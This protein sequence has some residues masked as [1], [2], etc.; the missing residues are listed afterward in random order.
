MKPLFLLFVIFFTASSHA[1]DYY[2][3]FRFA[4]TW[5]GSTPLEAVNL[6]LAANPPCTNQSA[7]GQAAKL[8]EV[9]DS[10][11][12]AAAGTYANVKVWTSGCYS[13]YKV[14]ARRGDSCPE[15]STYN[16]VTGACDGAP[17][18]NEAK[19]VT[20]H[21]KGQTACYNQCAYESLGGFRDF[22]NALSPL[23]YEY[24]ATGAS[25]SGNEAVDISSS[26]SE[27]S[28]TNDD[29]LSCRTDGAYQVCINAD[30]SCKL[31]N[32]VQVCIDHETREDLYNCGTFNGEVVCFPKTSSSGCKQVNGEPLC[33]YPDGDKVDPDSPDH[34]SNGGNANRNSSDDILDNQDIA[35][36]TPEAQ[37]VQEAVKDTQTRHI[38]KQQAES[39]NP[40]SSF[41]GIE[42]DKAVSCTGDAI[43]CAIA[44]LQKKQL[45]L[46][47]FNQSE[48]QK[49]IDSNPLMSP[50]G[51]QADDNLE[52]NVAD[53]LDTEEYV[54]TDEQCPEP[55]TFAVMGV[56]YQIVMTPLC[57]LAG[58]I[59][60]FILFA[61]WFSM[62]VILAKSLGAG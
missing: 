12:I 22:D 1:E 23:T 58:Y 6:Y 30:E 7:E 50:L 56:D 24:V 16:D 41:S 35:N 43:Q 42:C 57:D 20:S 10:V 40:T 32:G 60:Y 44:R 4:G 11:E 5:I 28:E 27:Y 13:Y 49:I 55:L 3:E 14:V 25:C 62:A 52:I 45:C 29:D 48:V 15:G 2:W 8:A 47:E 19:P 17:S 21:T 46:S 36:N 33:V 38:A 61:T 37:A 59:S 18:C 54:S 51:S 34:P 39:D 53:L 31:I 9:R 26:A